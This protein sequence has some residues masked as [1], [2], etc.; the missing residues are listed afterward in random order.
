M[1]SLK[2]EPGFPHIVE[3]LTIEKDVVMVMDQLG[4]NMRVLK[5]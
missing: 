5:E 3:T 1:L 4:E 2:K